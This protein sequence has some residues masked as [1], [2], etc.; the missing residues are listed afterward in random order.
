MSRRF[1]PFHASSSSWI[2]HCDADA[3]YAA[4]HMAEDQRLTTNPVVICGDPSSR[5]GVIVTANYLARAQGIHTGMLLYEAQRLCPDV[6]AI[7]P[8]KALYR[9][10]SQKMHAVFS[11]YATKVEPLAL[12]EAWLEMGPLPSLPSNLPALAQRLQQEIQDEAHLSVSIG[13]S[14]NKMLAKQVSDWSKPHGITQLLPEE[15]PQRLWPRE[16]AEL[17]GCGPA[18][19]QKLQKYAIKTIGDLAQKELAWVLQRFG[20]HGL[21]LY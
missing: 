16:I 8:D 11:R 2:F 10:Y 9:L 7:K 4:C 5:H 3:F 17:F 21:A 13:I 1:D 14:S 18:F 15:I 12:D 6:W 19:A 20:Q